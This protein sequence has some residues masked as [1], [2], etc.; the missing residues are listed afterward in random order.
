MGKPVCILNNSFEMAAVLKFFTQF[1][2]SCLL[3]VGLLLVEN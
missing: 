1:L 3:H 2:V